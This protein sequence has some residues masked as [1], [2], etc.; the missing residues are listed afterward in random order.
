MFCSLLAF[1]VMYSYGNLQ[2]VDAL[3]FGCSGSTES[4]LNTSVSLLGAKLAD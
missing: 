3:F 4:G 1:P 2:A